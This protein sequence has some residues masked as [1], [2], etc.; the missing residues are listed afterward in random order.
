MLL[1]DI[2]GNSIGG[3]GIVIGILL[4]YRNKKEKKPVYQLQTINLL[5]DNIS[6]INGVAISFQENKISSLSLSVLTFKNKGRQSIRRSDILK[7]NPLRVILSQNC[8][9][10]DYKLSSISSSDICVQMQ[11]SENRRMLMIAFNYLEKDGEFTINIFHT[12]SADNDISLKCK[13]LDAPKIRR[14]KD[15]QVDNTEGSNFLRLLLIVLFVHVIVIGT[16]ALRGCCCS[17]VYDIKPAA[18][19]L[20]SLDM[21]Y[22]CLLKNNS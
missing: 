17:D 22:D 1:A 19:S 15:M 5:D 10:L 8:E 11:L 4:Y 18:D 14:L 2:I 16:V 21:H 7:E 12:G 13:I 20:P 3:L 9:I 6:S